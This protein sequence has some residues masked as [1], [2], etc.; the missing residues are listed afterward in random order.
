MTTHAHHSLSGLAQSLR[1][2]ASASNPDAESMLDDVLRGRRPCYAFGRNEHSAWMSKHLALAGIVDDF[3]APG[4]NWSGVPVVSSSQLD[5]HA[6]VIN[7]VL[8]RRPHTARAR[9]AALP[10]RPGLL[11][12]AH[13]MRIDPR[14]F[15]A[16]PF[17]TQAREVLQTREAE[18]QG[19]ASR[20]ADEASVRCLYDVFMY[21]LTGDPEFTLGYTLRDQQQY[22]DVDLGLPTEG[23][24]FI[25]GGAYRGETT[26][27]FCRLHPGYGAVHLFE[28]NARSMD[29]ARARLRDH[30]N[31]CFHPQALGECRQRLQFDASAAN[32]S[33]ITEQGGTAID[34]VALDQVVDGPVHLLKYDLEGFEVPALRGA[35]RL[36]ESSRPGLA[37]CV[38]HRAVDFVDVPAVV[39]DMHDDYELRMRHYTEGWEETVLYFTP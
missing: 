3:V 28:P 30:A 6:V 1:D 23:A 37:I 19:L 16:L 38:Y 9:L 12:Y 7:A 31:I 20:L 11:D 35:R 33:H 27:E 26:E 17:V 2:W 4:G 36:I 8:H 15:G 13:C 24:V 21:R 22:F 25:D 5:T 18:L 14:R 10:N 32:A 29:S 39:L 34:V